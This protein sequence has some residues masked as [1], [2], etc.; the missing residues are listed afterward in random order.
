MR[1]NRPRL[2]RFL[3]AAL[4]ASVVL[5]LIW[6]SQRFL[7]PSHRRGVAQPVLGPLN[8]VSR[9]LQLPGQFLLYEIL[10]RAPYSRRL[11]CDRLDG[12]SKSSLP[13]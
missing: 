12:R 9:V 1:K 11:W 5:C 6:L 10:T 3:V 7:L 4:A 2:R 13:P 8:G